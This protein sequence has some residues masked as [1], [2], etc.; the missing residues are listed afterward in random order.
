MRQSPGLIIVNHCF[1][2]NCISIG[3]IDDCHK[4][5]IEKS[6]VTK[7]QENSPI[8]FQVVRCSSCISPKN[9]FLDPEASLLKIENIVDKLFSH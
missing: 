3:E 8:K 9:M 2:F 6:Q 7:L 5:I 1:D 4:H